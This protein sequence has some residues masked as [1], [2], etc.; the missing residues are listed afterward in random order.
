MYLDV[1]KMGRGFNFFLHIV[2]LKRQVKSLDFI[3][4]DWGISVK[5]KEFRRKRLWYC[6]DQS[7]SYNLVQNDAVQEEFVNIMYKNAPNCNYKIEQYAVPQSFTP[8][9]YWIKMQTA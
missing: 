9:L 4:M 1:K 7:C 6:T 8:K 5:T 2:S 3:K